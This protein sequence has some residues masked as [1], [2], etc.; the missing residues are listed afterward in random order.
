MKSQSL[1]LA[2]FITVV[3]G[4]S[5][6]C[7]AGAIVSGFLDGRI[8]ANYEKP[9][10]YD[11]FGIYVRDPDREF[12]MSEFYG[13]ISTL[14]DSETEIGA[15]LDSSWHPTAVVTSNSR[16]EIDAVIKYGGLSLGFDIDVALDSSVEYSSS[17]VEFEY[18]LQATEIAT[19]RK[20]GEGPIADTK[21]FYT[22]DLT[23]AFTHSTVS[24]G[25]AGT[26]PF[27]VG[28]GNGWIQLSAGVGGF[29][30]WDLL[31]DATYTSLT[32]E[33]KTDTLGNS[34]SSI[35]MWV[36]ILNTASGGGSGFTRFTFPHTLKLTSV[37]LEDGTTPEENGYTLEFASGA[38][39]PNLTAPTGTVPE[40][41]S[42]AIFG[43]GALGLVAS[44]IRRRK[45]KHTA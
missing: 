34:Q 45:R 1:F 20:S 15:S 31:P 4:I 10:Y 33:H 22:Y 25:Y 18:Y 26:D 38:K 37:L 35:S 9:G 39:S 13:T 8:F 7:F 16:A 14:I 40:P 28:G 41:T 29:I 11:S 27:F 23:G 6:P 5:Q 19:L 44:G 32:V 36:S 30:G 12:S 2:A 24:Q 17:N 43:F 3:A 42:L 21:L